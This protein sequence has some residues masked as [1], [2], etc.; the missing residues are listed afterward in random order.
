[1]KTIILTRIICV[2]WVATKLLMITAPHDLGFHDL[3]FQ[4]Q[5]QNM[6]CRLLVTPNWWFRIGEVSPKCPEF[7]VSN[8]CT[9]LQICPL[10]IF[11]NHPPQMVPSWIYIGVSPGFG[12]LIFWAKSTT[13]MNKPQSLHFHE[14]PVSCFYDS[15]N[16]GEVATGHLSF[17]SRGPGPKRQLSR[18]Q[19]RQGTSGW[20]WWES[21]QKVNDWKDNKDSKDLI[22]CLLMMII[23]GILV[24]WWLKRWFWYWSLL[25][26]ANSAAIR[27][28][29]IYY[30]LYWHYLDL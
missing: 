22:I 19:H 11:G 9:R 27:R 1:M 4:F 29:Y 15:S 5:N 28:I 20:I 21:W 10:N 8:Y 26:S 12:G 30:T 3:G 6:N 13:L 23:A 18:G 17:T 2:H 25:A 24:R 7:R 14:F 16:P